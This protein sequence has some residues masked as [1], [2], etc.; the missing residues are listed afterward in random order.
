[1]K[2]AID[3]LFNMARMIELQADFH[4]SQR[5]PLYA[6]LAVAHQNAAVEQKYLYMTTESDK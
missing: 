1:M 4:L 6:S 5:I 3:I 2:E